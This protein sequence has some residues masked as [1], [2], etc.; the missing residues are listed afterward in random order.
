MTPKR[1]KRYAVKER[2]V[3]KERDSVYRQRDIKSELC[4]LRTPTPPTHSGMVRIKSISSIY[5][6]MES[7][8]SSTAL[9][10][11]KESLCSEEKSRRKLSSSNQ[12]GRTIRRGSV[13]SG[14]S[15]LMPPSSSSRYHAR[16][17]RS[18][19]AEKPSQ[20]PK[21]LEVNTVMRTRSPVFHDS[22]TMHH[23]RRHS[24]SSASDYAGDAECGNI[25]PST[26]TSTVPSGNRWIVYGFL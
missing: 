15:R 20:N 2:Y 3:I 6:N 19:N 23:N 21:L 24:L 18:R 10:K 7:T 12:R 9:Y 11:S 22:T 14:S 25:I 5:K 4:S 17:Q 8:H 13:D 1:K 26:P 16:R